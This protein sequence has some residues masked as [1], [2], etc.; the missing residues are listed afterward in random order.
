MIRGHVMSRYFFFDLLR[1]DCDSIK[2]DNASLPF[3][4]AFLNAMGNIF[5][6][7]A[8]EI[9]AQVPLPKLS[10]ITALAIEVCQI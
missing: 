7:R 6:L 8:S 4:L 10:L 9:L 2:V 1:R 5:P 3:L